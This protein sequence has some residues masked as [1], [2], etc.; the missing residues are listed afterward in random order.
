MKDASSTD[1]EAIASNLIAQFDRMVRG[2]GGSLSLTRVEPDGLIE[3]AYRPGAD[4]AC[5]TGACAMPHAELQQLMSETLQRRDPEL[6]VSVR[7]VT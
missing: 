4:P 2:D 3:A 6:R 5:E 7:L 1:I